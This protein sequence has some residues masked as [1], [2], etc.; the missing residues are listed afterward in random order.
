M[1][2]T[3]LKRLFGGGGSSSTS[4]PA[5]PATAPEP[6]TMPAEPPAHA[7][8]GESDMPEPAGDEPA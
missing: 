7:G 4:E 2:M 5:A 6:P 8:T 3:W 1:T